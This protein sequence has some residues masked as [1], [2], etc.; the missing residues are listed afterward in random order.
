MEDKDFSCFPQ[1]TRIE[2]LVMDSSGVWEPTTLLLNR[3]GY[4]VKSNHKA[5]SRRRSWP[6]FSLMRQLSFLWTRR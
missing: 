2:L 4:L 5:R 1:T 3:D 6:M